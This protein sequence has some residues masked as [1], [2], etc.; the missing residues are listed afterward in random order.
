M[1]ITLVQQVEE[2]LME[3]DHPGEHISTCIGCSRM[4][5]P[6]LLVHIFFCFLDTVPSS[7]CAADLAA[8]NINS[9]LVGDFQSF[10][11]QRIHS[12]PISQLRTHL[13]MAKDST[14][15]G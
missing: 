9:S 4:L 14:V 5:C 10:C 6:C 1:L 7:R 15:H 12:V 11:F 13:C 3:L 8:K 2:Y